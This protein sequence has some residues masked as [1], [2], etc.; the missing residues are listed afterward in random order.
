MAAVF[1]G[2]ESNTSGASPLLR[3]IDA[4]SLRIVARKKKTKSSRAALRLILRRR[5]SSGGGVVV[6][7]RGVRA[8]GVVLAVRHEVRRTVG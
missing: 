1:G 2:F 7:E 5:K 3:V 4:R 6:V 8:W